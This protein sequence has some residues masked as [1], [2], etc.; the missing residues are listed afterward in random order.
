MG[1]ASRMPC[2]VKRE[3]DKACQKAT[4]VIVNDKAIGV[5]GCSIAKLRGIL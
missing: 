5:G 3:N 1:S 4:I 2:E